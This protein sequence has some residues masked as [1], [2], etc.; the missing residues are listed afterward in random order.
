MSRFQ[1]SLGTWLEIRLL[2][3]VNGV[4]TNTFS[5]FM[6]NLG[7]PSFPSSSKIFESLF[8][9][10]TIVLAQR[11]GKAIHDFFQYI[12][13]DRNLFQLCW[14]LINSFVYYFLVEFS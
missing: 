6:K 9:K 12:M 10:Q 13:V 7:L 4:Y 1:G 3:L 8:R 14:V 2:T 5:V 11:D